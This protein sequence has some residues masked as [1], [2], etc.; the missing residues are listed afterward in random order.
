MGTD[1]SRIYSKQIKAGGIKM[2][3]NKYEKS[4]ILFGALSILTQLTGFLIAIAYKDIL[5]YLVMGCIS[6]VVMLIIPL[7]FIMNKV[8]MIANRLSM[9]RI[10]VEK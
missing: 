7:I 10:K 4:M 8:E 5:Y 2:K 6:L 9:D 3:Y 1:V